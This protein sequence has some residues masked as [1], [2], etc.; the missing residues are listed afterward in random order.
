M[1]LVGVFLGATEPADP[2]PSILDFTSN[3][4]FTSLS[5]LIGQTFFIGDGASNTGFGGNGPRQEFVVPN[6]ATR[7]YLGFADAYAF[8]GDPGYYS[9][10]GGSRSNRYRDRGERRWWHRRRCRRGRHEPYP[11]RQC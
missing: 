7:L 6:G 4:D 5:P 11:E 3:A 8:V 1:F 9:D 10:N 2:A